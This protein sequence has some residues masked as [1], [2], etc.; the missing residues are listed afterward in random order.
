M[1]LATLSI[2]LV[3][4]V[5]AFEK[6]FGQLARTTEKQAQ[7][8]SA[9]I[10]GIATAIKGLAAGASV[11]ALTGFVRE[12]IDALDRLNDLAQ[13]TGITADVLGGLGFAA[14]QS[15]G[16]L[17]SVV[18][19]AGKLNKT[20]AEA[21]AGKDDA[22]E[23]FKALGLSAVD[24]SGK[25]KTVEVAMAEIA[26]KF[27]GFAD[28]PEKAALALR[29]FGKAGAEQIP[30]L[31]E[32]GAKLLENVEYYK[33][34]S[35]V[36]VEVTKRAD[37]FNDT[38]GKVKVLSGALG[39]TIASELLDPMKTL[40]DEFL[41]AKEE[42][43]GFNVMG[44]ALRITLETLA[45]LGA[46]VGFVFGG[47]GREIGATMA[48]IAA[49]GRGDLEGFKTIA[50]EVRADGERALEKLQ[51]FEDKILKLRGGAIAGQSDFG[52]GDSPGTTGGKP[53]AP[54]L[55]GL[56]KSTSENLTEAQRQLKSYVEA[57][58]GRIDKEEQLTEIQKAQNF[59][60]ELGPKGEIPEVRELVFWLAEKAERLKAVS[61]S[62]KAYTEALNKAGEINVKYLDGLSKD[63]DAI[64]KTN[65]SMRL[66]LEEMG[67]QADAL[68]RLRLVRLDAA[69]AQEREN[70]IAAQN[71]DGN[72]AEIA[73]IE[74]RIRLKEIE[75]GLVASTAVRRVEV[76]EQD[77]AKKRSESLSQSI[78]DGILDGF[79]RGKS[80]GDV[81]IDELKAQFGKTILSPII[82]PIADFGANIITSGLGALAGAIG[83]PKFATGISY[84]PHDMAAIIHKGERVVTAQENK[85]YGQAQA[86]PVFQQQFIIGD[87]A[88]KADV[89][90][91]VRAGNQATIAAWNRQ[92]NYGGANA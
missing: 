86:M 90:R 76:E 53:N 46:N 64:V 15:G 17:D 73:Q 82:K 62:Q 72:E 85:S 24:A 34:Y 65:E 5:A 6:D 68:D 39:V 38:L 22:V 60:L 3:A 78:N 54:R 26:D 43:E 21:A 4:K 69:I 33:R 49:L 12:T 55:P 29:G 88:S 89:M 51:A 42:G 77:A 44:S 52:P 67:L 23:F 37:E 14:S 56:P 13:Q 41:K 10:G 71:I 66:A 9:A 31:N 48:Q 59:L 91:A 11:G 58:Q 81:F 30:L 1:A 63:N 45:V 40:A 8:M 27:A 47:V 20:L 70:L 84:V 75:R 7:E 57:L 61:E 87:V 80:A 18:A 35:G 25:T 79:R 28:G 92:R 36:T 2:D 16:N 32:G 74:R 83:L 50:E 19:A